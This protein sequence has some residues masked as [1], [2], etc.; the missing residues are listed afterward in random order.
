LCDQNRRSSRRTKIDWQTQM[1][2]RV[3]A[4]LAADGEK[5]SRGKALVDRI[6]KGIADPAQVCLS[7]A[8]VERKHKH[9]PTPGV[10]APRPCV[11]LGERTKLTAHHEDESRKLPLQKQ[12]N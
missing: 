9:N 5:A 1:I 10:G 4:I 7:R 2:E 12:S 3:L 8:V 6:G 11:C